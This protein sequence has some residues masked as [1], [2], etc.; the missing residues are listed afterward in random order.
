MLRGGVGAHKVQESWLAGRE[1]RVISDLQK[2][3]YTS[4]VVDRA[5]VV[6]VRQVVQRLVAGWRIG[7]TSKQAHLGHSYNW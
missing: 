5:V 6:Q 3:C 7:D 1:K 4:L 2:S